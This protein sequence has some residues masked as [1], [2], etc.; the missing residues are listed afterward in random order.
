MN[1]ELKN[2]FYPSSICIVGASS[3]EKSIGYEILNSL[4]KYQ[5]K[6]KIFP[7]NP[8]GENILGYDCIRTISGIGENIDLAIIV[9]PKQ[10]V[11]QAVDELI[12]KGVKSII[13]ITAGYR[14]TG[15]EGKRYEE[16]LVAKL[17]AN[18][19]RLV[20]PNCMGVINTL[21]QIKLNATFVA[22]EPVKG[23]VAF[24]SQSGALGAAVLNSLRETD[25]RFAHFI[26]VGNKA[27]VSE[28]EL[29]KFWLED[30]NIKVITFYLESIEDGL[31]LVNTYKSA[32]FKKPLIILKAG[33]TE[34]GMK[35]ASSHTG[36]LSNNEK[37]T[38][39]LFNQFGIIR[40]ANLNEMFNTAKGFEDFPIPKGKNVA[41][42]TNAGGPAILAVDKLEERGLALANLTE[43]TNNKLREIVHPEGS[44]K[45][46]IDLLPG[47]SADI[48]KKVNKIVLE[49]ANVDAVISIF[50]E[51][52]MVSAFDVIESISLIESEK[53]IY[54]V[55]MPLPE[56][57]SKY[58]MESLTRK[59]VFKN[60]E[61]PAEIISNI[62]LFERKKNIKLNIELK[63]NSDNLKNKNPGFLSQTEVDKICRK[64]NLPVIDSK[65]VK[66]DQLDNF[67]DFSYPIV[68]K[69][70]SKDVVHKSELD[71]VKLN[72]E[73]KDE[74]LRAVDEI[75]VSFAANNIKLEKIFIQQ[76]IS[77]KHEI[78]VGGFRDNSF[79]PVVMFGTG[80]KY[81]EVWDDTII[82]S[83]YLNDEDLEE[84]IN[85]TKIGK[86]LKGVRGDASADINKIKG[87]INS[88]AKLLIENYN[89][90]EIDLNPIVVDQ[91]LNFHA[92]DVRIKVHD[93]N[94]I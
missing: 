62:L 82:K 74:M 61:D 27:D 13:L 75:K 18:N 23:G 72:I 84:M 24:L 76:Y 46:P 10:F 38:D 58:K 54:Q 25:I 7:V 65:V 48:Y 3:K 36:A 69:G 89:I 14:E 94:L 73:D 28:I 92:V 29:L 52:V 67:N 91:N 70:L 5:F 90:D 83:V 22:E 26:S 63:N 21:D 40:L 55:C 59:P 47:G 45:N 43:L 64:Y 78:L 42:I 8:K 9:L 86:I 39:S 68:I 33:K 17:K 80:G 79:G 2:F 1:Q 15:D 77:V 51:P 31:G 34:S 16:K 19:T 32:L 53:P 4:K 93:K 37:I 87:F 57:W 60:P 20:G 41:V 35:A 71:A 11:D 30:D 81:V 56:F 50:V 6:G 88:V 66:V 85:E 12:L 49:D 44:V